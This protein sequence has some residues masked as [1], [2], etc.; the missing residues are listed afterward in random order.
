MRDK[1]PFDNLPKQK[2]ITRVLFVLILALLVATVL[3]FFIGRLRGVSEAQNVQ[4]VNDS[5]TASNVGRGD[6]AQRVPPRLVDIA[7]GDVNKNA[8]TF[9]IEV[10][11]SYR[12]QDERISR[13]QAEAAAQALL[14]AR[15]VLPRESASPARTGAP[16]PAAVVERETVAGE[17][18]DKYAAQYGVNAS[19]MRH[20]VKCE[21]GYNPN[22]KNAN[23]TAS[24]YAQF[25]RGTW[26]S[27]MGRMGYDLE[28]SPFDGE[29]NIA[30][31]AYL[32]SVEGSGAWAASQHCWGL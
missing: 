3:P 5:K 28:T 13:E 17:L 11:E 4:T 20:I 26:R 21:S 8:D 12:E 29:K 30:A 23:S 9:T 27:V 32:L 24:G 31:L 16:V 2:R 15:S 18:I 14:A 25:I 7:L 1:P 6:T 10:G 19:L 22:A